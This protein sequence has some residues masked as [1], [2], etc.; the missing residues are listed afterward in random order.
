MLGGGDEDALAHQAGGV[1][2]PRDVPPTGGDWEIIEIAADKDQTRGHGGRKDS[3]LYRY[4]AVKPYARNF[5][6]A[7]Q[8]GFKS[9][10]VFSSIMPSIRATLS[11]NYKPFVFS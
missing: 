5:H 3:N 1:A 7:L 10:E 11:Q 8:G 6:G 2:D 9:Q 4:A